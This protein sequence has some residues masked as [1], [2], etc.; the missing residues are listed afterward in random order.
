MRAEYSFWSGM[1]ELSFLNEYYQDVYEDFCKDKRK[2]E[3][4][5]DSQI[6]WGEFLI[7]N[8]IKYKLVRVVW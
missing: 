8:R 2:N 4:L 6:K 3:K 7:K 1:F 5:S